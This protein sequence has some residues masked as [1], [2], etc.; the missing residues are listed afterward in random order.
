MNYKVV[1]FPA[2]ITSEGNATA[3]A[4]QLQ[5]LIDSYTLDGWEYVRLEHVDTFVAGNNGCF[6]IGAVPSRTTSSAMAVLR[7]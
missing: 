6:G 3:A 5:T 7:K 1:P 4:Q 2:S